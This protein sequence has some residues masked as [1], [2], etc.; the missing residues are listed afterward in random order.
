MSRKPFAMIPFD[1]ETINPAAAGGLCLS[2][3]NEREPV[4]NSVQKLAAA[5][6]KSLGRSDSEDGDDRARSAQTP[7]SKVALGGEGADR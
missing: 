4:T 3:M 1:P 5:L 7:F 6:C 2:E